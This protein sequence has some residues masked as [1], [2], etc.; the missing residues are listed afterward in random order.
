MILDIVRWDSGLSADRLDVPCQRESCV[1]EKVMMA[2]FNDL[3][4]RANRYI[5]GADELSSH[6]P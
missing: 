2:H 1:I 5:H 4:T 3:M 6:P